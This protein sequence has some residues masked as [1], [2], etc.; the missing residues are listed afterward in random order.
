M[1]IL[2]YSILY[3]NIIFFAGCECLVFSGT[4][5]KEKGIFHSPDFPEPYPANIDC[6]LYTFVGN[7][8]EIIE[9]NLL[10]FDVY[11]T[12]LE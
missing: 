3:T 7:A 1:Q 12:N 11:K 8:D 10:E 6:L 9:I 2:Y 5:G 4:F